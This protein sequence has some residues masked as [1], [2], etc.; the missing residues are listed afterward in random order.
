MSDTDRTTAIAALS[1]M[2][3]D[4]HNVRGALQAIMLMNEHG[5]EGD[6]ERTA[7]SWAAAAGYEA[8]VRLLEHFHAATLKPV[9]DKS[10]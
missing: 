7:T 2:E 10:T 4:L 8:A 6:W 1:E 5:D 3:H 9:D